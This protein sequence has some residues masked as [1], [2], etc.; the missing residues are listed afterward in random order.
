MFL[1]QCKSRIA[2]SFTLHTHTDTAASAFLAGGKSITGYYT[3]YTQSI[4]IKVLENQRKIV[5]SQVSLL[6]NRLGQTVRLERNVPSTVVDSHSTHRG[7]SITVQSRFHAS[8]SLL[9]TGGKNELPSRATNLRDE[10]FPPADEF[11][12]AEHHKHHHDVHT[13][14]ESFARPG[15]KEREEVRGRHVLL[16]S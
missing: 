8:R 4:A 9:V 11:D 6:R 7:K 15:R 1:D 16:T 2:G 10:Y 14:R 12:L 13:L 5:V 3:V